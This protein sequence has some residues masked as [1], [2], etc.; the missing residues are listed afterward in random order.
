MHETFVRR[1]LCAAFRGSDDGGSFRKQIV[2]KYAPHY[3]LG[4]MD[5]YP[6]YATVDSM[7]ENY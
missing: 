2:G 5:S 7:N 6:H 4:N 3:L 1:T